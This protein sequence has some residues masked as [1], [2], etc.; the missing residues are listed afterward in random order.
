MTLTVTFRT[1]SLGSTPAATARVSAQ[2]FSL[3]E[4]A[5]VICLLG[6]LMVVALTRLLPFLD[7]AERVGV[8]SLEGQLRSTLVMVAAQRIVNGRTADISRLDGANPM[9][10]L[11]ETPSNYLGELSTADP[12]TIP[13]RHWYFDLATHRLVY[14]PGRIY[15][16]GRTSSAR[17]PVEFQVRVAFADRDG[18]GTFEPAI[19]ELHGV[20]LQRVAG[21][22]WLRSGTNDLGPG[23]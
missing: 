23:G 7:E 13:P 18:S 21:G 6:T 16:L 3:L 12:E 14:A 5:V 10:F 9:G 11:L 15:E 4:L 8:L 20:R 2:G 17:D 1:P 19:D 22:G